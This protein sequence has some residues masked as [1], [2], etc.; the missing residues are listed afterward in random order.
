[1]EGLAVSA[2]GTARNKLATRAVAAAWRLG[3]WD[4]LEDAL[5]VS[6]LA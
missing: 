6:G 2:T 5:K 4:S 3:R 1:M